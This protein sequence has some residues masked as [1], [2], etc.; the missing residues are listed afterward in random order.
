MYK[1]FCNSCGTHFENDMPERDNDGLLNN[2][3][4]PHCGA[5]VSQMTDKCPECGADKSKFII[6]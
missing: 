2:I 1:Y 3:I 5:Y 6:E 4:C